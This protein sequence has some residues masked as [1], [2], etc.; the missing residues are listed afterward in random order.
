LTESSHYKPGELY[1]FSW[2]FYLFLAIAGAVWLGLARG[3]IPP[4]LFW[5]SASW[6][7]DLA[8]GLG[9]AVALLGL[10]ELGRRR[11]ASASLLEKR[12]AE[13]L[14]PLGISEAISLAFLSGIAEELFFRG[15]IQEAWGW[16]PAAILFALL[17]TGPGREFRLWTAFAAVAGLILG[18]ITLW[19]DNLLAAIVTHVVVNGVGLLRVAKLARG[20]GE[21]TESGSTN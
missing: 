18:G 7:R 6:W 12:V 13:I 10:W 15:A 3:R 8:L 11:L 5:N 20:P 9:G 19:S 4:D 16:L 1:R 14:G 21:V 17:H 2:F